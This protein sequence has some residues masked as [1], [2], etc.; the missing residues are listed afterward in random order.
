MVGLGN[1]DDDDDD[2]DTDDDKDDKVV[3]V[4][5]RVGVDP[6]ESVGP[7]GRME[8]I[9]VVVVPTIGSLDDN[10]DVEDG[11]STR[12]DD[13]D[14]DGGT[15][16][17]DDREDAGGGGTV[18]EAWNM[19]FSSSLLSSQKGELFVEEEERGIR[20]HSPVPSPLCWPS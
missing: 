17:K 4:S 1:D 18:G 6:W 14:D 10:K 13:D 9:V 12:S 15:E 3:G 2:D 7:R 11:V 20:I 5:V 8:G 16:D 19:S